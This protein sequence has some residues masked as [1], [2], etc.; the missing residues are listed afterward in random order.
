[1]RQKLLCTLW[2]ALLFLLAGCAAAPDAVSTLPAPAESPGTLTA[3]FFSCGDADS[4]LIQAGGYTVLIDTATNKEGQNVVKR[5]EQLGVSTIDLLIIS[6]T[7]KDHVGGA[8]HV[9]ERFDVGQVFMGPLVV[10]SKQVDQFEA[11]LAA[12]NL[13]ARVLHAGD[14]FSLGDM[15]F[16]VLG[17][18]RDAYADENDL[19]LVF[20]LTWGETAFLFPGD[21]E[22]PAL[23]DLLLSGASL[24]ADVLKVPHHGK[25]EDNSH[26]FF[27]AVAPSVA[28]IPCERG[29]EDN[30]PDQARVVTPLEQLGAQ[31]FVTH[32]GE[33]RVQSD[34]YTVT[35]HQ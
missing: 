1:M 35:A 17:P 11:A 19:S 25:G 34:G 10:D 29:T 16:D 7:H 27:A 4:A 15:H 3:T 20:R 14:T 32:D 12:R 28:V 2:C 22:R 26:R 21:A 33:I 13:A 24:R 18:V 8:D 9:L 6:H 23:D 30:L 31:I 5:L